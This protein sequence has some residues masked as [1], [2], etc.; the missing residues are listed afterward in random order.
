MSSSPVANR[1]LKCIEFGAKFQKEQDKNKY[2]EDDLKEAFR[3]G[4]SNMHY[5]DNFGLDSTLTEQ[6]WF[7]QFKKK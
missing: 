1:M 7:E 4:Q 3:Q 6:Q 5:S 2:S